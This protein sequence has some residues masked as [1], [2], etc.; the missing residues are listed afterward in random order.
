MFTAYL[1]VACMCF[2]FFIGGAAGV[3]VAETPTKVE[4]GVILVLSVLAS[5]MWPLLLVGS[6][7]VG[8]VCLIMWGAVRIQEACG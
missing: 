6:A 4:A 1:C 8:L 2:G 7:L 3:S 5:V